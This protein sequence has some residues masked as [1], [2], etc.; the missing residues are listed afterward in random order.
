MLIK[1]SG[2]NCFLVTFVYVGIDV[3]SNARKIYLFCL[4]PQ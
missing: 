4:K 3:K 1:N 2:K